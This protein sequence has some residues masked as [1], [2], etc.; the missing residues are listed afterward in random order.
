MIL[1]I[2]V[3]VVVPAPTVKQI[4]L[5]LICPK[6]HA[7]IPVESNFCPQCGTDLRLKV[8]K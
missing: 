5:L 4:Q 7:R 1:G 6:C 2:V 3:A 8:C